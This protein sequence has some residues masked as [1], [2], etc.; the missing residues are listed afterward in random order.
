MITNLEMVAMIR[1]PPTDICDNVLINAC[2]I[3]FLSLHWHYTI[4]NLAL[5]CNIHGN[6]TMIKCVQ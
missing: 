4:P 3:Y 6:S 5:F 1:F 2:K